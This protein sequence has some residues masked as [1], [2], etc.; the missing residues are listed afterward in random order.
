MRL[1]PAGRARPR[2]TSG[3]TSD[4]S[5]GEA[6]CK[7]ELIVTQ[8]ADCAR[9]AASGS[10][11]AASGSPGPP[12]A[13]RTAAGC[14]RNHV[15]IGCGC[16]IA[17]GLPEVAVPARHGRPRYRHATS[18][19]CAGALR[20]PQSNNSLIGVYYA[21]PAFRWGASRTGPQPPR[22]VRT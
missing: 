14:P 6:R 5:A 18:E 1:R 2:D 17:D 15:C 13:R 12:A 3:M 9:P 8:C 11:A 21:H 4:P 7:H 20:A 10:S 22:T 16:Q 19:D